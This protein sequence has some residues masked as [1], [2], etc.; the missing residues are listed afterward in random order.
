M[1]DI[2]P[3][4]SLLSI[5][6]FIGGSESG[7]CAAS[8]RVRVRQRGLPLGRRPHSPGGVRVEL[9]Q[10]IYESCSSQW[11]ATPRLRSRPGRPVCASY[12]PQAQR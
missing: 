7:I 8:A 3:G 4:F 2:K 10:R 11:R 9:K 12:A 5:R 6:M 1:I